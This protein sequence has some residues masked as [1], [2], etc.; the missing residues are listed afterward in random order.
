MTEFLTG[1][2]ATLAF[3]AMAQVVRWL[4]DD[5]DIVPRRS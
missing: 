5:D 1:V 4:W 2:V 3:L